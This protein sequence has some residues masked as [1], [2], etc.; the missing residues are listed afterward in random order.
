MNPEMFAG[1][2]QEEI[3]QLINM[4]TLDEQ[5]EMLARQEAMAEQLR[6]PSGRQHTTALG[7]ALG[8]VGDIVNN[9]SGGIQAN[10]LREQ[11]GAIGGKKDAGRQLYAKA[12]IEAL[13]KQDEP[14]GAAPSVGGGFGLSPLKMGGF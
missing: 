4:G 9:V 7:A 3:A 12:L 8:G 11:R 6:R 10:R 2:S 14:F 5:D 1:L 13:R